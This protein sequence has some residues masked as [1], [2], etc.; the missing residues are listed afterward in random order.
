MC[1]RLVLSSCLHLPEIIGVF[2]HHNA[3]FP[4]AFKVYMCLSVRMCVCV[5]VWAYIMCLGMHRRQKRTSASLEKE[6]ET[7]EGASGLLPGCWI[8]TLVFNAFTHRGHLTPPSLPTFRAFVMNEELTQILLEL[9]ASASQVNE[10]IHSNLWNINHFQIFFFLAAIVLAW[11]SILSKFQSPK[12]G[13]QILA[14]KGQML[15]VP[16]VPSAFQ[17]HF[18]LPLF[19]FHRVGQFCGFCGAE[20]S[21]QVSHA[22]ISWHLTTELRL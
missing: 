10:V 19:L 4:S 20:K 15:C 12:P 6:L 2:V 17:L 22:R 18:S 5:H 13:D 3:C 16:T 9:L 21:N 1:P 14:G 7:F 8:W 11:N